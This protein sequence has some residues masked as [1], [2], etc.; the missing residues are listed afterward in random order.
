MGSGTSS[1]ASADTVFAAVGGV[2]TAWM[3]TPGV[4][5]KARTRKVAREGKIF[6]TVKIAG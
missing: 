5:P 1:E 4:A 2:S 3:A 6:F